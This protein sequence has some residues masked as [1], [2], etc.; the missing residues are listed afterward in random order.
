MVEM[1]ALGQKTENESAESVWNNG[2]FVLPREKRIM[3]FFL[4]AELYN[5]SI[6]R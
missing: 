2:P 6:C 5:I 1:A 4:I 3:Q